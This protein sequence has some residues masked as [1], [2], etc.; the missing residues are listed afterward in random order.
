MGTDR[1]ESARRGAAP[2][3]TSTKHP[4]A[5]TEWRVIDSP[6]YAD[7]TF[8][9]RSLLVMM[10]RQLTKDNNGHLQATFSYMRRFGFDSERT[11]ARCI[12]ELIAHGFIARTRTGGYQQG[13]SQ[14]AVTWLSITRKEGLFLD[15]FKSC[16]WRDWQPDKKT[17]PAKMQES[18][19]KN[20]ILPP[21]VHAKNAA[22]TDAKNE[23][24]ELMPCTGSNQGTKKQRIAY[25]S[26]ILIRHQSHFDRGQIKRSALTH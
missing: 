22:I 19:G 14:Y 20:G 3:K 12:A 15:S 17:P 9:A 25:D 24:I 10:T 18:T 26:P 8:S 11:L 21:S 23:D 5:A 16:A 13:A 2:R 4:Y 1:A 6:S 7:L